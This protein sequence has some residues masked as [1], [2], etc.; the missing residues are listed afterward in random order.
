[1]T[2]LPTI[3][4][5]PY[6]LTTGEDEGSPS[7][8]ISYDS[9]SISD[10]YHEQIEI[11]Y[12][13]I[14]TVS[15]QFDLGS[16]AKLDL[17]SIGISKIKNLGRC[18]RLEYLDLSHNDIETME[19]LENITKLKRLNLSNNKI[20]KLEC[21]SSLKHLQHLNLEKNNIENLTDIQ[22]LQYVPNLKSINLKGNPV[23]E[24]EGFDETLKQLC[25][26]LQFINGEHIALRFSSIMF[27][28]K[29]D[30]FEVPPIKS[31]TVDSNQK[32]IFSFDDF[33]DVKTFVN[34]TFKLNS[35]EF[36]K[37]ETECRKV[38]A[39]ADSII[40]EISKNISN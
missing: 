38:I 12:N 33:P 8:A 27:D 32:S 9:D 25:K 17:N 5:S 22:E 23:C 24:K 26:K 18:I 10:G 20:K 29:E 19:G 21:I 40:E 34:D 6:L 37:T 1:M 4:I 36:K 15:G 31:W 16:V 39:R 13:L 14:S 2:A 11:D 7:I 28:E 3:S 35:N 30:N